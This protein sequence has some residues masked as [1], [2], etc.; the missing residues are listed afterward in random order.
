MLTAR[1][2][3]ASGAGTSRAVSSAGHGGFPHPAPELERDRSGVP[4]GAASGFGA[5]QH[6]HHGGDEPPRHAPDRVGTEVRSQR[7]GRPGHDDRPPQAVG[8]PQG[9]RGLERHGLPVTGAGARITPPQQ[10]GGFL[11]G[12]GGGEG[13]GRG[14][15]V[16][17]AVVT[18]LGGGGGHRGQP[19]LGGPTAA[20][21]LGQRLDVLR[22]EQAPTAPRGGM[23][24]QQPPTHIGIERGQLDA[25]PPGRLGALEHPRHP[26]SSNIEL[27]N[28]YTPAGRE[29]H[30]DARRA[31]RAVR[32]TESHHA[33]RRP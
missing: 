10:L 31:R 3:S 26:A 25:Q 17:G 28:I 14:P 24:H 9:G 7:V 11:V 16:H 22:R 33:H 21:P 15:P 4:P 8:G 19:G 30:G 12:H 27:I 1:T 5:G 6:R 32:R 23:R 18:E 20:R 13:D 2:S 29:Q